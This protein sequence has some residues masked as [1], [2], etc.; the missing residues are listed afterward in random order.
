MKKLATIIVIGIILFPMLLYLNPFIWGM[1]REP[2]YKANERTEKLIS[3]LNAKYNFSINLYGNP[4]TLWYF[5]DVRNHKVDK[6]EN[7]HLTLENLDSASFK[8]NKIE[9][10]VADFN[11]QFEHKKYFDSI[12]VLAGYRDSVIYKTKIK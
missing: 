12:V 1:R 9:S 3:D 8:K 5:R 10:Y 4:D 2:E 6:L 7:F 11:A